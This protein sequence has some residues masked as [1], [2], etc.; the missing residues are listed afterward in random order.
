M[1]KLFVQCPQPGIVPDQALQ[2]RT[3]GNE[4]VGCI[5]SLVQAPQQGQPTRFRA[6]GKT[7]QIRPGG[8]ILVRLPGSPDV[9]EFRVEILFQVTK[10]GKPVFRPGFLVTVEHFSRRHRGR[11]FSS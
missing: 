8:I 3:H 4:V 9:L 2:V 7:A 5:G 6:P 10:E 1:L 11:D